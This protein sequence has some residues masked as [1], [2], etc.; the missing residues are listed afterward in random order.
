MRL[1]DR[2]CSTVLD[3]GEGEMENARTDCLRKR[4]CDE[5]GLLCGRVGMGVEE[6]NCLGNKE[7]FKIDLSIP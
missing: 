6:E 5:S 7:A 2:A 4:H 1:R 3:C